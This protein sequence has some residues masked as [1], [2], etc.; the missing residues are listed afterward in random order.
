MRTLNEAEGS[1]IVGRELMLEKEDIDIR[2]S[3]S[4]YRLV[5]IEI[6]NFITREFEAGL[7]VFG[8]VD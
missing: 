8:T 2:K 7:Q 4:P 3:I 5:A 6:R 1:R